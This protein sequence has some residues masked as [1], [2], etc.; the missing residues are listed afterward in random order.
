MPGNI[1]PMLAILFL[2]CAAALATTHSHVSAAPHFVP[3]DI[4]TASAIPYPINNVA[5]GLVSFEVNLSAAGEVQNIQVTRDIPGLT[6]GAFGAVNSWTFTPG[7][8]DGKAVPST[9]NVQ[10]VFNPGTPQNQNLQ[11]PPAGPV[12][13]PNPPGYLPPSL[14]QVS[15]ATYPP[16]S[17]AQGTVVLDLLINK[18]SEVK[19]VATIRAVPSLTEAAK[20]AVRTWTVNPATLNEKKVDAKLAVAFIFRAPSLS[21]P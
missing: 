17:I 11:L 9:I 2:I 4:T 10:I 12:P 19:N 13:A 7:K 20:A 16:N 8:L 14:S 1:K 15:Y 5:A 18:F 21:T 3:P 6:A